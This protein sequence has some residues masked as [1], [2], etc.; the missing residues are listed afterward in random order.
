MQLRVMVEPQQGGTYDEILAL[1]QKTEE[2]GFDG[3]FRSD[4]LQRIGPGDPGPGST[5][6]WVTLAGL[7]RETSRI[8][9]GTMV[10]SATF[11]LAGP[12]AIAV[13]TVDAM[14]GGRIELGLGSGWFEA[15]HTS[16]GVP[17]LSTRERLDL[18]EEQLELITG[19]WATPVGE[20]YSFTGKHV[21]V[22]DSPALPKPVQPDG[23]PIIVGGGGA[24]RTPRL[25][26]AYAQEFNMPPG[27]PLDETERQFGIVREACERAGRD[28]AALVLSTVQAPFVGH[29]DEVRRAAADAGSSADDMRASGLYGSATEIVDKLGRLAQLGSTRTYLQ[30]GSMTDAAL[31]ERLHAEV[32]PQLDV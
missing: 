6:A 7:A 27:R 11:R 15:E 23:I 25:A 29:D 22:R 30:M 28:P 19:L 31:L 13:A 14:S 16:Y 9:L 5:D 2:L 17:F 8:R 18:L 20:T 21:S 4:H 1:A 26:A 10:S 24:V 32:V 12:L 3:F